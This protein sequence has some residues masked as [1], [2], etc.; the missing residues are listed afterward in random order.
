VCLL[1][2]GW[3]AGNQ[4]WA[5]EPGEPAPS[6][7]LPR[8]GQ[9]GIT[10]LEDFVGK[11]VYVDFW[12]SWCGPCRQSLPL[13]ESLHRNLAGNGFELL[14][15]NLDENR[16]DAIRFLAEHPVSYPVLLDPSGESARR[17]AVKA[18]PSSYLIDADG[19]LAQVYYGFRPSHMERIEHAIKTL[20][21]NMPLAQPAES[22]GLR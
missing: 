16:D 2:L 8:L 18:M 1:L 3:C 5:L 7:V 22:G 9:T 20:L 6:L 10:Q 14:A 12:A 21:E 19:R 4:G 17:W 13:Y 11:V 15:V